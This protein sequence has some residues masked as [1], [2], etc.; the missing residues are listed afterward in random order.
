M[1]THRIKDTFDVRIRHVGVLES[2]DHFRRLGVKTPL[3]GLEFR[4]STMRATSC[5]SQERFCLGGCQ[6]GL[7]D[8]IGNGFLFGLWQL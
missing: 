3:T 8:L 2:N 7:V 4:R 6:L 5:A 1:S